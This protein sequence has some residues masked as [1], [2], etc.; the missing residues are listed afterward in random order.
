[1]HPVLKPHMFFS[2]MLRHA[3]LRLST[4]T[5]TLSFYI[6]FVCFVCVAPLHSPE[7]VI[8]I[9]IHFFLSNQFGL[10]IRFTRFNILHMACAARWQLKGP[11]KGRHNRQMLPKPPKPP[12]QLKMGRYFRY[13]RNKYYCS[14]ATPSAN[15]ERTGVSIARHWEDVWKQFVRNFRTWYL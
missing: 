7:E 10:W 9:I 1:M 15:C 13:F 6:W 12:R 5:T 14:R 8:F 4:K 11:M 2:I 3:V